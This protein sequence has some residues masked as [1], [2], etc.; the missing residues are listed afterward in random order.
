MRYYKSFYILIFFATIILFQ[1]LLL[2]SCGSKETENENL[3]DTTANT[4]NSTVELPYYDSAYTYGQKIPFKISFAD[5][6]KVKKVTIEFDKK[7]IF[8]SS[9][10]KNTVE[11]SINSDSLCVGFHNVKIAVEVNDGNVE[12]VDYDITLASNITPKTYTY[13]VKNKF[14]HDVNAYTQ[15]LVF[16]NGKMYESTGLEGKSELR[17]V[18]FKNSKIERFIKLDNSFFGEGISVIDDKIYQLTWNSR[19]GF[20]YSKNDFKLIKD[21][22]YSTEGWG[23]CY[24]GK[25]LILSDGTEKLFYYNPTDF[26]LVKTITVADEITPINLLNELEFINGEIWA[27][28][29]QTNFIVRIDPLTGRIL[30]KIDCTGLLTDKE[31]MEKVDVLNGIAYDNATGKI[32]VTGKWWPWVFEIELKEKI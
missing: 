5:I 15:G 2:N 6:S 16:E 22:S 27:N 14:P 21:F 4:Y 1:S 25:N 10:I 20:I 8:T 3:Y 26:S 9:N 13:T 24:D 23:L 29:Y 11:L 17:F 30:S 32:Y 31:Q 12:S 7:I 19:K 28:V 18:D